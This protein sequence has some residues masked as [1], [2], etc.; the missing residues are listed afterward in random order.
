MLRLEILSFHVV[1]IH[2]IESGFPEGV[3]IEILRFDGRDVSCIAWD[4]GH[5]ILALYLFELIVYF[6]GNVAE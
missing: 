6:F 4:F 1:L 5:S 2:N 3:A